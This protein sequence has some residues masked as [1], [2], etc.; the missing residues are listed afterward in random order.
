VTDL[1]TN[2]ISRRSRESRPEHLIIGGK[3]YTRND[4]QAAEEGRSERGL[5]REDAKGCPYIYIGGVK[6]RP[7]DEYAEYVTTRIQTNKPPAIREP[8]RRK[9]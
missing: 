3:G 2:N 1:S 5:N 4:V 7:D 6:Y 9:R 8:A